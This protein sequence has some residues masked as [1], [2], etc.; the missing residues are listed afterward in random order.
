MIVIDWSEILTEASFGDPNESKPWTAW[1]EPIFFR[2]RLRLRLIHRGFNYARLMCSYFLL[3]LHTG[4]GRRTSIWKRDIWQLPWFVCSFW[5][6]ASNKA[7]VQQGYSTGVCVI[8]TIFCCNNSFIFLQN[9]N[10]AQCHAT[11]RKLFSVSDRS[12]AVPPATF[13]RRS[14]PGVWGGAWYSAR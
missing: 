6:W 10:Q 12:W 7:C 9:T 14:R 11:N 3:N 5:A 13:L 8:L 1:S 2:L 4:R